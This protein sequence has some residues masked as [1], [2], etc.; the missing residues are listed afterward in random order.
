MPTFEVGRKAGLGLAFDDEHDFGM[1]LSWEGGAE[2]PVYYEWYFRTGEGGD[3]ED[4]VQRIQPRPVDPRV[5]VRDMDIAAPGF[6]MPVV[7]EPVGPGD[8]PS[9]HEGV[10]G[11]EGALKAPTMTPKPLDPRSK[12][13][14]EAAT[15]VDAPADAQASG[16]SDPVVAP[17]LVGGWHALL[18]RVDPGSRPAWPHELNLD[19]RMR[20][21]AGLGARVVGQNQERYMKLA[22]EQVGEILA[23]NRKAL[24]LRFAQEA[25][26]RLYVKSVA[27]LPA[28]SALSLTSPVHARVRGS[29]QTIRGLLRESRLPAAAF[30]PAFRKLTRPRGPIARRA[31]P[32]A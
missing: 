14:E 7:A 19:P 17:P 13:P 25:A 29:P 8:P 15:I 9:H 16:D 24:H 27:P 20:A 5:G 23:A 2:F 4:L 6:G 10:V 12:F 21:A 32:A 26:N 31:L 28:A 3:F 11:L 30:S 1:A 18:D 22:W